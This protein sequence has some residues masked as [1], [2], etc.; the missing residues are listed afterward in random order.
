M[1]DYENVLKAAYQRLGQIEKKR[2]VYQEEIKELSNDEK[3]ESDKFL[4][5]VIMRGIS[6]DV[7]EFLNLL[8]NNSKP[9]YQHFIIRN[10]TEHAIEYMYLMTNSNLIPEYFGK[11]A[12]IDLAENIDMS[13]ISQAYKNIGQD[14]Y[15][16]NRTS[17]KK[18]AKAIGEDKEKNGIPGLYDVFCIISENCHNSYFQEVVDE[19][20]ENEIENNKF[21]L[22]VMSIVLVKLLEFEKTR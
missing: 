8:L 12:Q 19:W 20:S 3:Q 17:V 10:V 16:S 18:M 1:G 13:N 7:R 11:E 21:S 2:D 6:D 15:A 5:Y 9:R 4:S 14:R 22:W